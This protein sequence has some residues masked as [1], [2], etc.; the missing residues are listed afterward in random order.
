MIRPVAGWVSLLGTDLAVRERAVVAVYGVRGVGSIYYL[1]YAAGYIEFVNEAQLWALVAFV[2]LLS[3]MLHGLTAGLAMEWITVSE[4]ADGE[5]D[6]SQP[7]P[8]GST[9]ATRQDS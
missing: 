7:L 2:I 5:A 6:E 3:T 9:D 4:A 1:A 8:N